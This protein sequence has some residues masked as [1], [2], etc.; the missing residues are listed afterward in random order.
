MQALELILVLFTVIL[1]SSVLDQVLTRLS[2]P[3][4]QIAMGVIGALSSSGSLLNSPLILNCSWCCSL[5]LCCTTSPSTW[6]SEP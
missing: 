2:L 6:P 1:V 3:L 5:G 4:V